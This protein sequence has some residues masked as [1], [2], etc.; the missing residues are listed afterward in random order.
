MTLADPFQLVDNPADRSGGRRR[1]APATAGWTVDDLIEDEDVAYQFSEGRFE[2]VEGAF[3]QLPPAGFQGVEPTNSLRDVLY[4]QMKAGGHEVR[5]FTETDVLLRRRRV[6]KPDLILLTADQLQRHREIAATKVLK[7]NQYRP[8]YVIP[9]LIV[10]SISMGYEDHDRIT[11]RRWYRLAGVP[12]YWLLD[13]AD[14]S[15][16]CLRLEAG[17][18]R[19]A[20]RGSGIETIR[21]PLFGGVE[22]PL[23]KVWG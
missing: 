18:Y 4:D 11:K 22:I 15:L 19:R 3:V 13:P 20:A 17:R 23:A 12:H 9:E 1:F 7:P 21:A 5:M 8:V 14:R 16:E 2:L 10:E 6:P